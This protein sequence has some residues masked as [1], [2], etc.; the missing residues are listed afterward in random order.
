MVRMQTALSKVG[1]LQLKF[2]P[3][4]VE[5][6]RVPEALETWGCDFIALVR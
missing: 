2:Y 1:L 6:S 5:V 4:F 3:V